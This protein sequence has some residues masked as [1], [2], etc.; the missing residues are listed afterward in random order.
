MGVLPTNIPSWAKGAIV[1]AGIGVAYVIYKKINDLTGGGFFEPNLPK[2]PQPKT[3]DSE[4]A[5]LSKT[6]KLSYPPS[7]FVLLS[8]KLK[9][10]FFGYGTD[11]EAVYSVFRL[12]KNNLD[13]ATLI[14][15]FG[16]FKSPSSWQ[17]PFNDVGEGDL[18]E[19]LSNEMDSDEIKI[20]NGIL[21]SKKNPSISFRF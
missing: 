7:N 6:L 1:V 11:E 5:T 17:Q 15:E 19:W 21:A 16:I 20:V 13:V 8:N 12:M 10:S 18:A 3:L 9:T 2:T 14:K 4:I